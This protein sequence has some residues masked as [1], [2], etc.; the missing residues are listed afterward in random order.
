MFPHHVDKTRVFI[1]I[2]LIMIFMRQGYLRNLCNNVFRVDFKYLTLDQV[3]FFCLVR[4]GVDRCFYNNPS[5]LWTEYRIHLYSY[6]IIT[7]FVL[8]VKTNHSNVTLSASP[9]SQWL[10][11]TSVVDRN[12]HFWTVLKFENRFPTSPNISNFKQIPWETY[13][14]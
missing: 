11:F 9:A 10:A 12:L 7:V 6:T 4:G 13:P 1:K 5:E 3:W 14:D 8:Y 2:C